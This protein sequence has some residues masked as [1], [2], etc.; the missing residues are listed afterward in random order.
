MLN[1]TN[2]RNHIGALLVVCYFELIH[3]ILIS[4]SLVTAKSYVIYF[5]ITQVLFGHGA[6]S[7][8]FEH[9]FWYIVIFLINLILILVSVLITRFIY[10]VD[11]VHRAAI[12]VIRY[13]FLFD[14]AS[15]LVVLFSYHLLDFSWI[16]IVRMIVILPF[17]YII[18]RLL[19][20]E[21]S[22]V[23]Q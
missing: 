20:K 22:P 3:F 15:Y 19:L 7:Y 21:S 17:V 11:S 1:V 16:S 5:N 4:S 10:S 9:F 23:A 6:S 13:L 14:L 18:A 8:I 12:L 2:K